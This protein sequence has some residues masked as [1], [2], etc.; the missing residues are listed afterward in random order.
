MRII[1][2]TATIALLLACGR[3]TN[4]AEVKLVGVG[5][6][7]DEV[8]P[9]PT[10]YGGVVEYDHVD[11]AAAGLPLSL[12]GLG[13]TDPAGPGLNN[14]APPYEGIFGFSYIFD[15]KLPAGDTL[16]NVGSAPPEVEGTCYTAFE[17]SGPIGS[18]TTVDVGDHME[19]ATGTEG[20]KADGAAGLRMERL[21]ADYPP[22]AQDMFVYYIG[23]EYYKPFEMT[24]KVPSDADPDNPGAMV[25]ATYR[26]MNYPF[27]EEVQFRYPGGFAR[28]DQAISS[29]PRPSHS[30][31]PNAIRLPA[32]LGAVMLDWTGPRYDLN[33][34][35]LLD[36]GDRINR[37]FEFYEGR[38]DDPNRTRED[39]ETPE[40]LPSTA[41]DYNDFEGQ[42]YTGPWDTA[43]GVTFTWDTEDDAGEPLEGDQIVLSVRWMAPVDTED[44]QFAHRVHDDGG[45]AQVCD[46][47]RD[48]E[49]EFDEARYTTDGETLNSELR[50]DPFSQMATVTCLLPATAGTFTL[51]QD[52]LQGALDHVA[53]QPDGAGGVVFFFSR[54]NEMDAN[55]VPSVKDQFS[56]QH[57]IDPIKLTARAIRIGRFWWDPDSSIDSSESGEE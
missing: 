36:N 42:V 28:F 44:P 47:E 24:H 1:T 53:L 37:C 17:P 29:M 34:E 8:G 23:F 40:P 35:V 55:N 43:D 54:G 2:I 16:A 27:G 11:F 26:K 6:H 18:F 32:P 56:Q 15:T 21:P 50:G 52:H 49:F 45:P 7:P 9:S 51:T 10:P 46:D 25:D 20:L 38:E 33:G 3:D 39:C 30:V 41:S 4:Q 5:Y 48:L 31:D 57:F 22:D 13:G 12:M 14:F 19:F